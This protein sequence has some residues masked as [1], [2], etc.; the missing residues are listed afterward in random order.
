MFWMLFAMF[1]MLL[2]MFWMLLA[3]TPTG[4]RFHGILLFYQTILV[5]LIKNPW[6]YGNKGGGTPRK[7]FWKKFGQFLKMDIL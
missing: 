5:T 4:I 2:A 1:W 3:I 6:F 7:L